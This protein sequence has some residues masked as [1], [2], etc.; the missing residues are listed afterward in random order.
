VSLAGDDRAGFGCKWA[1]LQ[2]LPLGDRWDYA[3]L[4][5]LLEDGFGAAS[6]ELVLVLALILTLVQQALILTLAQH[7][8]F[9][10]EFFWAWSAGAIFRA[11]VHAVLR[12]S[13]RL[14]DFFVQLDGRPCSLRRF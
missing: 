2:R 5:H 3:C 1:H 12:S 4:L 10:V 13:R 9:L 6:L 11:S 14:T 8:C 7:R